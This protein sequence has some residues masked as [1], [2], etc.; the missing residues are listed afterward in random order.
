MGDDAGERSVELA[1]VGVDPLRQLGKD[2]ALGVDPGLADEAA[3]DGEAS[4]QVGR[5]D[6][7]R[8]APLEAVAQPRLEGRELAWNAVCGEDD[9][10]AALVERVEGVEELVLGMALA[11]EEL[12]VVDEQHVEVSVATLELL[13]ALCAQ[14]RDELVGEALGGGVADAEGG[15]RSGEVVGDRDQEMGLAETRR[16]VEKEGVVGLRRRLGYGESGTVGDAVALADHEPVEGVVDVEIE[17]GTGSGRALV[18]ALGEADVGE[19]GI[20]RLSAPRESGRRSGARP[21]RGCC[22]APRGR[23]HPPVRPRLSAAP[24]RAGRWTAAQTRAAAPGLPPRYGRARISPPGRRTA[25]DHSDG[26]R[27]RHQARR[28]CRRK[29]AG[30]V[31][32]RV[33]SWGRGALRARCTSSTPLPHATRGRGGPGMFCSWITSRDPAGPPGRS[34][35]SSSV[36]CDGR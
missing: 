36:Y 3:Q 14:S 27:Q 16:A 33:L 17:I 24:A 13:C 9:L 28:K 15:C 12:D 22:R 30:G 7:D 10:A 29:L 19:I 35:S 26:G 2:V 6:R 18:P 31:G 1:Y 11:L 20:A 21:R 32:P 4:C 25:G 5:L 23:G 8:Q 34:F